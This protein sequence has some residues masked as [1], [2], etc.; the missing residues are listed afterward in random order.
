V[1]INGMAAAAAEPASNP[2]PVS[3]PMPFGK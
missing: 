2:A 1:T 3:Q